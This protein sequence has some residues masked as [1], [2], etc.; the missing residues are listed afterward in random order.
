MVLSEQTTLGELLRQKQRIL[1]EEGLVFVPHS[2][3][4][5][6]SGGRLASAMS[7]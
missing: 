7:S 4:R 5:Y 2:E 1:A 3:L 6:G